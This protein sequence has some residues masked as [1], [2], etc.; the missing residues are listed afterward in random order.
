M[1]VLVNSSITSLSKAYHRPTSTGKDVP[2]SEGG[3][4]QASD[5]LHS[6]AGDDLTRAEDGPGSSRQRAEE[7]ERTP[8]AD[9]SEGSR[10][11]GEQSSHRETKRLHQVSDYNDYIRSVITIQRCHSRFTRYMYSLVREYT[12]FTK[13]LKSLVKVKKLSY[14]REK[15][16]DRQANTFPLPFVYKM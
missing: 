14:P 5:G 6:G 11:G 10:D 13:H 12:F 3:G 16:D 15:I 8:G 1:R 9:Q 7:E 2:P 4:R